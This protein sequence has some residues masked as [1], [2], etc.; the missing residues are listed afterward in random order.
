LLQACEDKGLEESDW[1]S[2]AA[3]EVVERVIRDRL[4]YLRDL[5][6]HPGFSDVDVGQYLS[7]NAD[8]LDQV[9]E[10]VFDDTP[11]TEAGDANLTK[12]AR[13]LISADEPFSRDATLVF[14]GFGDKEIFPASQE[15]TFRGILAGKVRSSSAE[16][17]S[18]S[19]ED[20]AS[21][22]PYAQ[23]EAV[24]TFLR[25]YNPSF[26]EAA[27]K[28]IDLLV[29]SLGPRDP[30]TTPP[31]D[32]S[33]PV[34]TVHA[35]LND[36]FETLSWTTFIEPL[37]E[38]VAGLPAAELARIAESLVGLQVLRQLTQAETETVGGP[39]DVALITRDH[40]VSWVRHKSI[41]PNQTR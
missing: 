13:E 38:T 10:W 22:S 4:D 9:R 6:R 19:S 39:V 25:G 28:R 33:D 34:S 3:A 36:D 30:A 2:P 8:T 27:H 12:I 41:G 20:A 37:V 11:R 18:I 7:D 5:P 17:R 32:D 29:E 21:I 40:G 15:V 31:P 1:K 23:T 14:V 35:A 26:L 24:N 16:C